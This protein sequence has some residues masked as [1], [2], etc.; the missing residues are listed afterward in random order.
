M[1]NGL[2]EFWTKGTSYV[3]AVSW[4]ETGSAP[5]DDR[6]EILDRAGNVTTGLH[7]AG[8]PSR[9]CRKPYGH[10]VATHILTAMGSLTRSA[11]T[12]AFLEGRPGRTGTTALPRFRRTK[13]RTATKERINFSSDFHD[14]VQPPTAQPASGTARGQRFTDRFFPVPTNT[15]W[16]KE[17]AQTFAPG[18]VPVRGRALT[19]ESSCLQALD[20]I[21]E[22]SSG[23]SPHLWSHLR[24]GFDVVGKRDRRTPC[25]GN[26]GDTPVR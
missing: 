4:K 18:S 12:L 14:R 20:S 24:N 17:R 13:Y 16:R 15:L 23:D 9:P 6:L 26:G 22:A 7:Q 3:E 10:P 21:S 11:F 2:R 25:I 1:Y 8:G 19:F 5:P